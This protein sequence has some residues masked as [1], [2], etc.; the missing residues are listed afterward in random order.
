MPIVWLDWTRNTGFLDIHHFLDLECR[1]S[2]SEMVT[3]TDIE[4]IVSAAA[5]N[6]F[7]QSKAKIENALA[8]M[9]VLALERIVQSE[10]SKKV[11]LSNDIRIFGSF[12]FTLWLIGFLVLL[13]YR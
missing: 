3:F 8:E 1:P 6:Q 10:K 2:E 13:A 7:Y 4:R 11:M 5:F 9:I 12:T